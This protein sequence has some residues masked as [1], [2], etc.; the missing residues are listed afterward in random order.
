MKKSNQGFTLI[1]LL[2]VIVII[3]IIA[4]FALPSL[5]RNR[6]IANEASVKSILDAY[7]KTQQT[8]YLSRSYLVG[9]SGYWTADIGGLYYLSYDGTN[10]IGDLD[11]SVADADYKFKCTPPEGYNYKN[12]TSDSF[13]PI[14]KSGYYVAVITKYNGVSIDT[15][16][17]KYD[18]GMLVVP[19]EYD[20]T[21]TNVF[22]LNKKGEKLKSDANGKSAPAILEDD[23]DRWANLSYPTAGTANPEGKVWLLSER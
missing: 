2:I 18:Y 10:P 16:T 13:T 1:E 21:G 3:G 17:S 6:I 20:S 8:F 5:L 11:K 19:A 15:P 14:P 12:C 4:A 9:G 7:Y 22:V 23:Y